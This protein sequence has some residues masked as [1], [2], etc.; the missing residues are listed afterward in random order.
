MS[1]LGRG[2]SNR[3]GVN[4]VAGFTPGDSSWLKIRWNNQMSHSPERY[5][6]VMEIFDEVCTLSGEVREDRLDALCGEDAALRHE[7][8]S[9]L[10]ADAGDH[11]LVDAVKEGKSLERIVEGIEFTSDSDQTGFQ[12]I[13]AYRI[14]RE[15]G[16]GGM[17]IIYEAQQE[18]PSRRVAMKVL[19]PGLMNREMLKRFQHEAHVLGQLQHSGIAQIFEAGVAD[20]PLGKQPFLVMELIEGQPLD[21]AAESHQLSTQQRLELMA[22]VCDAVQHAHQKGVIHRDLKPSN[23]LVSRSTSKLTEIPAHSSSV[24]S[25]AGDE[26]GQPKI[27]DFGIARVT[28][29]DL[30]TVTVQTE[31]GQLVGTLAY[32]SPEQVEGNSAILDTRCD[33]YALGVMLFEL[34]TGRRPHELGGMPVAEAARRVREEDAPP[35]GTIDKRFRGD[36]ETIVAMALEIDRERRYG[37]ASEL[38]ADIRRFLANEPIQARPATTM[39]LIGRFAR[40]NRALVAGVAATFVMLVVAL[41]ATGFGL[42]QAEQRR[43]TAVA[44]KEQL[45]TVVDYQSAMLTNI[46]IADMGH[47]LVA[48]LRDEARGII[49]DDAEEQLAGFESILAR[50]NSTSLASRA[51]DE[52]M[53][54][55][56]VL[57]LQGK[58]EN[59]PVIRADLRHSMVDIY[60]RIGQI[61]K[62]LEQ[63]RVELETRTT[64]QGAENPQ[65]L[66]ARH[67]V[68]ALLRQ[69]GA[70]EEAEAET[71]E[72]LSIQR[73]VLGPEK[74]ATLE[75]QRLLGDVLTSR[76]QY[77]EALGLLSESLEALQKSPEDNKHEIVQTRLS[78]ASLYVQQRDYGKALDAYN[79]ALVEQERTFGPSDAQTLNTVGQIAEIYF[80][81]SDYASALPLMRRITEGLEATL[82][83]DHPRTL[84]ARFQLANTLTQMKDYAEAEPIVN[85]TLARLRR[86]MGNEHPLTVSAI[87][88]AVR[89]SIY[90]KRWNEAEAYAREALAIAERTVGRD[91]AKTLDA[92]NDLAFVYLKSERHEQGE[93]E[94][95]RA[96]AEYQRVL[97]P[98]HRRTATMH[99]SL[100]KILMSAGKLEEAAKVLDELLPLCRRLHRDTSVFAGTLGLTV[101]TMIAVDRAAD[102][103]AAAVELRDWCK[104]HGVKGATMGSCYVWIGRA[105]FAQSKLA[106]AGESIDKALSFFAEAK[107]NGI[108][109]AALAETYKHLIA[110]RRGTANE[111]A[112][113]VEA[114]QKLHTLSSTMSPED[115]NTILPEVER[116]L[117]KEGLPPPA[118]A[119]HSPT[120]KS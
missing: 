29:S 102:A 74:V 100:A 48:H 4:S 115:K 46:D 55:P 47:R 5:R 49:H 21:Q 110:H 73:R 35:L 69:T 97:G 54:G 25:Y 27:L 116:L 56:A 41:I 85:D 72:L 105:Q 37:S 84:T 93:Q 70:Y 40:R 34:L 107:S 89:L 44:A 112:E 22:R 8:A 52:S 83:V 94:A 6:R 90:T 7:V 12:R 39:Y 65:T 19:R 14:V 30:Q 75:T 66:A 114:F 24:V 80:F 106:D 86:V 42:V 117:A 45:Q 67:R 20:T 62:S 64:A 17:G 33:V 60:E 113:A 81:Q 109:Q 63:A 50:V 51:L 11:R 96:L 38:A 78:L 1:G 101:T 99:Q 103:E 57:A 3:R 91:N 82:G 118:S 68:C 18:S 92:H 23:V 98:E 28:D 53:L 15:I 61:E 87:S 9:M 32:M 59:Q 16:R 119:E 58:F 71:R 95:R 43:K 36:V 76:T 108:W 26:I 88:A 79:A 10:E 120:N 31:I 2:G 104:G 111:G 77:A 13:G